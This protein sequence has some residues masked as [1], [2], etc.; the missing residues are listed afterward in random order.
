MMNIYTRRIV[1]SL[2]CVFLINI[3]FSQDT[4]APV[5]ISAAR[6]TSYECGVTTNLSDKL[7]TW[8]N[9]AGGAVF[10]DNSG[11]FTIVTNITL[12]QAITIFNNSL[13]VL[14][15]NKQK[16][17]VTFSAIDAAGNTSATTT[18]SFFT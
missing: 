7:T 5:I 14:C 13:D 17:D 16:V 6:D 3:A 10:S 18:A 4:E 1:L 2:L 12:A 15:G 9:N 11:S 8:F